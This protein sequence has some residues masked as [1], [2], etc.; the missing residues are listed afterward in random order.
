[1]DEQSSVELWRLAGKG[2]ADALERLLSRYLPR[3]RRWTHGRLPRWARDIGDTDDLL[4]ETVTQAL[5]HVP[6]LQ[7]EDGS[8]HAYLRESILNRIRN[9]LRDAAR[10]PRRVELDEEQPG[11]ALSPLEAAIT[12][13]AMRRYDRAL[14]RLRPSE[15][16]AIIGRFELG[17]TFAELAIAL[18]KPT[19]DAARVAVT[20]AVLRLTRL[21]AADAAAT[22]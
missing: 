2:N 18:R 20:R 13:E 17:F 6:H 21:L 3:L 8:L 15:R 10:R 12:S 7:T 1:M 4:Q 11:H 22:V 16:E 19:P 9:E 14:A 5:K